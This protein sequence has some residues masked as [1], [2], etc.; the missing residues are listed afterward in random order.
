[1][2][3]SNQNSNSPFPS[4]VIT[5]KLGRTNFVTWHAQV[6]SAVRGAQL[7]GHLDDTVQPPPKTI[8]DKEDREIEN[9]VF[10][11]WDAKDQQVLSFLL[12]ALS[13][14]IL[15]HAARAQTA[16]EAWRS[17]TALFASQTRARVVNLRMALATTKKGTQSVTEYFTKMKGFG[18]EMIEAG[19][20]LS[21]DETGGIRSR[22]S[23][24]GV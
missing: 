13:K 15:A 7:Q 18:D 1:M 17:I 22:R 9:P 24:S 10:D 12:S 16:A 19:R 5:E 4:S 8:K 14:D 20:A 6:R 23:W 2:S 11:D 3:S 21:D